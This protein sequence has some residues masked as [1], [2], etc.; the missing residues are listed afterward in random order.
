MSIWDDIT[1][2]ANGIWQGGVNLLSKGTNA[3]LSAIISVVNFLVGKVDYWVGV[4]VGQ[5]ADL[6]ARVNALSGSVIHGAIDLGVAVYNYVDNKI[7]STINYVDHQVLAYANA[8]TGLYSNVFNFANDV[9]HIV[10]SIP[11]SVEAWAIA[12]I[13]NP[14]FHFAN[15]V[16]GIVQSLPGIVERWAIDNIYNPIVSLIHDAI[17]AAID[18]WNWVS[19]IGPY[20]YGLVK[21]AEHWLVW[22]ATLPFEVAL[23]LFNDLAH[24]S[25]RA[26]VAQAQSA[27]LS[28]LDWIERAV[29]E[30]L[31]S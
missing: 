10:Q 15:D 23:S 18:A 9:W 19:T 27:G 25:A 26:W 20:L 3:A 7:A 1:G 17:N 5:T 16:W 24:P 29:I 14:V 12:N 6:Y 11:G 30:W 21:G 8:L 13:Y 28:E 2:E 4:I 22:L 31:E